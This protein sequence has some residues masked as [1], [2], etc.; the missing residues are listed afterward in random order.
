MFPVEFAE[1]E[2]TNKKKN[3]ELADFIN[4]QDKKIKD[5]EEQVGKQQAQIETPPK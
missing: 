3:V 5:L 2:K 4:Y 1:L